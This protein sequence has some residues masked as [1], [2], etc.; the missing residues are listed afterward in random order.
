MA[1]YLD[2]V[3]ALLDAR[4]CNPRLNGGQVTARCP[5]HDDSNPSLSVGL[6]EEGRILV[7]CHAGCSPESVVQAL[8]IDLSH[9][10]PSTTPAAE[11]HIEATYDYTDADGKLLY[12]VVRYLPKR[13]RQRRPRGDGDWIWNLKGVR[14]VLYRLPAV[15]ET[16]TQGGTIYVVEGEKD[17]HAAERVGLVATCNP[18]GAGKWNASYNGPLKGASVIIV[19][20]N[21]EAGLPHAELVS[22]HLSGVAASTSVV[23][24]A[25]GKDLSDH[26]AAG[27]GVEDLVPVPVESGDAADAELVKPWRP[28]PTECL[29]EPF[30]SLIV[31]GARSIGCDESF[32]ALPLM[33]VSTGCIGNSRRV[34]IKPT[35]S[36]ALVL[37]ALG[38]GVSGLARKSPSIDLA[39][40]PVKRVQE[41]AV[42]GYEQELAQYELEL[43]AYKA[44]NGRGRGPKDEQADAA[45]PPTEPVCWRCLVSD[46]TVEALAPILQE[47]ER[48][49]TLVRDELA[50]WLQ[51]FNQYRGGQGADEAFWL[52]AHRAGHCLVDRRGG[53]QVYAIPR[54]AISVT[55]MIQPGVLRDC[56]KKQYFS[57]GLAARL[58]MAYPPVQ[59]R[60]WTHDTIEQ[61]VLGETAAVL[62]ALLRLELNVD[63]DG[64]SSPHYIGLDEDALALFIEYFDELGE[65]TAEAD[66]D[67]AAAFA[68]LEGYAARFAG[69][70][71]EV[72]VATGEDLTLIDAD[73]MGRA[74]TLARWFRYETD[75]VYAMLAESDDDTQRRD[76]ESL[77]HIK[78]G[79]ISPRDL[80]HARRKYRKAGAAEAALDDL[81]KAGRGEWVQVRGDAGGRPSRKLRLAPRDGASS[82]GHGNARPSATAA[83]TLPLPLPPDSPGTTQAHDQ[84]PTRGNGNNSPPASPREPL[85]LPLTP[86]GKGPAAGNEEDPGTS[87]ERAERDLARQRRVSPTAPNNAPVPTEPDNSPP[88]QPAVTVTATPDSHISATPD[89]AVTVTA[90]KPVPAN[91]PDPPSSEPPPSNPASNSLIDASQP[92]ESE[93]GAAQRATAKLRAHL[94][95]GDEDMAWFARRDLI[96]AVGEA[97]ATRIEAEIR[98]D[99]EET[100]R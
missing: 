24:A 45:A 9:L 68:K 60:R 91:E 10:G 97:E 3:V 94:E 78:G 41:T 100:G 40:D 98:R 18:G 33:A 90:T 55:G 50:G 20:D 76:L 87:D 72:R 61:H 11:R 15:I 12:Q 29:P 36:E 38:I 1:S 86:T 88:T 31:Q 44:R 43:A 70:I 34:R 64:G 23:R 19:A 71:H 5:A 92:A 83:D 96:T 99:I 95:A 25:T 57:S 26:L 62:Q 17:V 39:V 73:S 35:W 79:E 14:R 65:A 53:R 7:H 81:A 16:A 46:T 42:H 82:T 85:P 52:E 32:I 69:L 37:W 75:R 48:G 49:L 2:Q 47:N 4:E 8:G 22:A 59:P 51:S 6:G 56:L 66:P 28:F 21:D 93:A 89:P 67:L 63:P 80:A 13:F 58:L 30:R 27:L 84:Q 54:A 74:I 77:I